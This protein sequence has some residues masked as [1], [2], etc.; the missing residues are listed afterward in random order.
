MGNVITQ[1]TTGL[2]PQ[3]DGLGDYAF[4][5]GRALQQRGVDSR[6]VIPPTQAA[7]VA[8]GFLVRSLT[9]R[10]PTDLSDA[11]EAGPAETVLLH[12]VGYG[13][14]PSGL[15]GWLVAGL[16]RWKA[17]EGARRLVTVFHELYATGPPWQRSFWVSPLQRRIARD[18]A[19]LSD[20]AL[21]TS[22][23]NAATLA[24]WRPDLKVIVSPVFSNVG[25]CAAPV[26]L[27]SRGPFGVIFGKEASRRRAYAALENAGRAVG[28]G[29]RWL[30]VERLWDIGPPMPAPPAVAGLP[31]E[32]L[33]ALDAAAVSAR[34]VQARAGLA[35]YPLHV[36]TKSG[37]MAAYFAHGLLAVNTSTD[38]TLPHGIEEGRH[39]VQPFRLSNPT[40]RAQSVADAGYTWYRP[41]GVDGTVKMLLQCL[42]RELSLSFDGSIV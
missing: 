34:L 31:V 22:S 8:L 19:A 29:L 25:E 27:A 39:F 21:T 3:V 18:L 24:R 42:S 40:F 6:F 32:R 37:V 36:L 14:A 41:H 23:A 35:D 4:L 12:F 2:P 11:L 38:G 28:D 1:I 9:G 7:P 5:L 26:P 15:C 17:K 10:S 30:G 16:R 13:Y 33:G 20:A